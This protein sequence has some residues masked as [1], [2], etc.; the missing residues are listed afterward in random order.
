MGRICDYHGRT[1]HN[2]DHRRSQ[3]QYQL[4]KL[5]VWAHYGLAS[6]HEESGLLTGLNGPSVANPVSVR[7]EAS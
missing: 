5:S 1:V 6:A 2:V 7:L 4:Y 3:R